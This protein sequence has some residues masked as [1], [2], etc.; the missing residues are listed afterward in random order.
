[1]HHVSYR[2]LNMHKLQTW[3]LESLLFLVTQ[4]QQLNFEY[5][6]IIWSTF[7]NLADAYIYILLSL[8]LYK[9]LFHF[10]LLN[11]QLL[12]LKL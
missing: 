9:G 11:T 7:I 2:M 4:I 6:C 10:S 1:M 5:T 12:S 3:H 8:P